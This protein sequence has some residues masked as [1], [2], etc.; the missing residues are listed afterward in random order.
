MQAMKEELDHIVKNEIWELDLRPKDIDVIGTK[1]VF[2]NKMNEQVEVVRNK[3]KLFCKGYLQQQDINY[4]ETYAT[5]ARMEVAR[6]FLVYA[7]SKN[8]KVYQM[9]VKSTF[10]NEELEEE[11]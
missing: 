6:M 2:K 8:F 7:A 3:A 1:W 9:D 11:I 4:E 10:M 5:M